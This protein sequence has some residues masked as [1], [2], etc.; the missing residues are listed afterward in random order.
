MLAFLTL[1]FELAL[2]RFTS[3]EVLYL[4]YFANFVLISVFLGIGLGFLTAR[5][6]RLSLFSYLPQLILMMVAFVVVTHI[7][8]TYLRNHIGQLFFGHQGSVL[9]LPL[10][11]CLPFIFVLTALL[12]AAISQETARAFEQFSPI[13]AYSTDIAGSW[14]ES[15]CSPYIPISNDHPLNGLWWSWWSFFS[16]H[17]S[18]WNAVLM[19]IG[20]L[21]WYFRQRTFYAVVPLPTYRGL[22]YIGPTRGW[23][24]TANGIASNH[25][26]GRIKRNSTTFPIRNFASFVATKGIKIFWCWVLGRYGCVLCLTKRRKIC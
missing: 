17:G 9:L 4:G 6:E 1:Y 22:A 24:F 7:D 14:Q 11:F 15:Y 21:L 18:R 16:R 3:A 25:D 8:A 19:A 13:V 2:I 5:R 26:P 20:V 23:A 10:W 12:F